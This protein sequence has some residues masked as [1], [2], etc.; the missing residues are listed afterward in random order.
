MVEKIAVDDYRLGRILQVIF[1]LFELG[2][3]GAFGDVERAVVKGQTVW[4]GQSRGDDLR[5]AFAVSVDDSIDL[6][7]NSVADEHGALIAEPQRAG[8]GNAAG[9]DF[10]SESFR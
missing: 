4:P 7:E 8:I 9:I 10:H 5:F 1:D 2:N 6:V 3:L